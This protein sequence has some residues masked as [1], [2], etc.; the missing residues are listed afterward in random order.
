MEPQRS[1]EPLTYY[2]R[3]GP[4]GDVMTML[5]RR[6]PGQEI[7]VIGLGSA[8]TAAYANANRR[9]SFFD[10]DYQVGEIAERFFTFLNRCGQNCRVM[11]ADGRRAIAQEPDGHFDVLMLDAFSSDSIP[12]HLVSREA[13]QLY[14]TKLKPDGLLVF[15]VSN[16]YLRVASLVAA[17]VED[18]GLRAVGRLDRD[19]DLSGKSGSEYIAAA[20]RWEHL[21]DL[22]AEPTWKEVK[23]EPG[24]RPW[25]DDYSN[26]LALV[27]WR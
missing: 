19:G 26:M 27:K 4:L 13:I 21:L 8:S 10:V 20:R 18:A 12:P 25:T 16:R 2:H 22:L 7:G 15:H 23:P 24:V 5:D 3:S 9:I 11:I 17:A 1:G 14:L 6:P